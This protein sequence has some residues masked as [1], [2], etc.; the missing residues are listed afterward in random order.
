M[1]EIID[2]TVSIRRAFST[3]LTLPDVTNVVVNNIANH[4]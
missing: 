2:I 3:G 4:F 1:V